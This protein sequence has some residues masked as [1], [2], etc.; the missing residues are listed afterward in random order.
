MAELIAAINTD[1]DYKVTA[2]SKTY[3]SVTQTSQGYELVKHG[4]GS[5]PDYF[6]WYVDPDTGSQGSVMTNL[7]WV[8]IGIH[9][10]NGG[11]LMRSLETGQA[12]WTTSQSRELNV[13]A[14]YNTANKGID[15]APTGIYVD[16]TSA[17]I[18]CGTIGRLYK[19]YHW[20]AAKKVS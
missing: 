14:M 16:A 1:G 6:F 4:I 2:G 18:Y 15:S 19:T 12:V 13:Y 9:T 5:K 17:K 8:L 20:I 7:W 3:S 10:P 11:F